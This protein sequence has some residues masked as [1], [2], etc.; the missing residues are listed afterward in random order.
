MALRLILLS[1]CYLGAYTSAHA[2]TLPDPTRP[3]LGWNAAT[4]TEAVPSGPQLQA[5][6]SQGGVRS[7]LVDGQNVRIGSKIADAVVTRIDEDRLWMRGPGGVQELKL[8]P[9]ADKRSNA[10]DRAK[11]R[12]APA[13][14]RTRKETE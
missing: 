3:A 14:K 4:Q 7:A 6:R 5:I 13:S 10:P 9:E 1:L 12:T 8:F 11:K 2:D